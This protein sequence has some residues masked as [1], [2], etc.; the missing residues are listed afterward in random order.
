MEKKTKETCNRKSKQTSVL[1]NNGKPMRLTCLKIPSAVRS[2]SRSW[3]QI[4]SHQQFICLSSFCFLLNRQNEILR[5]L[6]S[7]EFFC[8]SCSFP[9]F[10]FLF[11]LFSYFSLLP[12]LPFADLLVCLHCLL[13]LIPYFPSPVVYLLR[14]LFLISSFSFFPYFSSPFLAANASF[15]FFLLWLRHR[16]ERN[17]RCEDNEEEAD[18]G[19]IVKEGWSQKK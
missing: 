9:R 14:T 13:F 18:E 17:Q 11:L 6:C 3:F 5:E 16:W 1:R 10:S 2:W 8:P 19:K 4:H 7:E 12:L 15:R